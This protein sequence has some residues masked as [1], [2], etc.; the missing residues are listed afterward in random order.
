MQKRFWIVISVLVVGF[1][2][3]LWFSGGKAPED[4]TASGSNGAQPTVFVIGK[5]DA[6]VTL[7]EYGDFQCSYCRLYYPVV[8]QTIAKYKDRVRFEFRQYPLV[9]I[10]QNAFAAARATEAAGKQ[11]KFWEMY[12]LIYQNQSDWERAGNAKSIFEGYARQI[13]MD[14]AAYDTDFASAA[15]NSAINAS[16]AEFNSRGLTKSTPTFLLNGK[17]VQPGIDTGSFDKL[18]D[19]ALAKK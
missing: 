17:K 18:L 4:P 5:A 16:I 11:N 14:V 8:E 9:S 2:G 3:I 6:T 10:H 7:T 19:D 13:G 12:R 1:V 15:T